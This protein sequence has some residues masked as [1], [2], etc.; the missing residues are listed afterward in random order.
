MRLPA[1]GIRLG[2]SIGNKDGFFHHP[3]RTSPLKGEDL[4]R[5]FFFN[6]RRLT[7]QVALRGARP[8][9]TEEILK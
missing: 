5:M 4:M 9:M 6:G 2:L 8:L 7:G 1:R 3:L